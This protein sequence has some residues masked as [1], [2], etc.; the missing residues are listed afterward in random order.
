[1]TPASARLQTAAIGARDA[2]AGVDRGAFVATLPA[3]RAI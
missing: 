3:V 1:M 2:L